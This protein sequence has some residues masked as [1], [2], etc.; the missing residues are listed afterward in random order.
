MAYVLGGVALI[1]ALVGLVGCG[2]YMYG[3][4]Q[5]DFD[6]MSVG[7]VI[8][9]VSMLVAVTI[10]SVLYYTGQLVPLVHIGG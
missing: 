1:A 8:V 3:M 7:G 6:V 10:T 5:I 4:F 2:V 9:V